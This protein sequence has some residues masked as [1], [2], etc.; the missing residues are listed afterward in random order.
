M[1]RFHQRQNPKGIPQQSP[2]LRG[3]SYPGLRWPMIHNPNAVVASL[4]SSLATLGFGAESLW[5]SSHIGLESPRSNHTRDRLKEIV[6]S[7]LRRLCLA[8]LFF[9]HVMVIQAENVPVEPPASAP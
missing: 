8:L 2:G 1:L 9:G 7:A 3:A 4:R 6:P 5:D